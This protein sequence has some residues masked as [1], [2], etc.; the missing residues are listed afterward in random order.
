MPTIATDR[1]RPRRPLN[2][3]VSVTNPARRLLNPKRYNRQRPLQIKMS[4]CVL[5][6]ETVLRLELMGVDCMYM[7]FF[8]PVVSELFA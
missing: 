1:C 5:T 4:A 8:V 6:R 2:R 3:P 7:S